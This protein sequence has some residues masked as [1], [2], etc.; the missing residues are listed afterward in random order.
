MK[1][2]ICVLVLLISSALSAQ[3]NKVVLD[4]VVGT[5][6]GEVVL[7]S[8]IDEQYSYLLEKNKGTMPADAKCLISEQIFTQKLLLNQSKLDSIVVSDEEVMTQVNTK[9]ENILAYMNNDVSQLESYYGQTVQQLKDQVREDQKN[10]MLIQRMQAK[11]MGEIAVTPSEVKA[12]YNRIPVDSLPYFNAEVELGEIIYKPKVSELE[13][14]LAKDKLED[15]RKQLMETNASFASLAENYSED[16]GSARLGGDL[17]WAKRGK[18][19]PE[20]EAAAFK[21]EKAEISPVFES[22]F[23]FHII[24]MLERRGNSIHT[25]HILIKPK[26]NEEDIALAKIRLDSIAGL[27]NRDSIDF[28]KSVKLYSDKNSQSFNNDGRMVNPSSNNTFFEMSELDP[29]IF[30]VIDTMKVG[31]ISGAIQFTDPAGEVY[32]RAVKLMSRTVP[33]RA[34]LK[35][36]YQKIH[37][38]VVEQKRNGI[39]YNWVAEK[40]KRTFVNISDPTILECKNIEKDWI[41]KK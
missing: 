11:I 9:I 24:Q 30:F 1:T 17:G 18:F 28:S 16:P 14:K 37:N 26:I 20:F 31:R 32:F 10:Q 8:E 36:D 7:Q 39:I 29:E 4:K 2:L 12:F 5:I 25:R 15:L 34:S 3:E 27:L 33:H 23:G 40:K 35:T 13:K 38:F 41:I 6:G 22:D 19:V 21:L